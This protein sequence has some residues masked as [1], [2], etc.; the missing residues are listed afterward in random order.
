MMVVPKQ[1]QMRYEALGEL[2][3]MYKF[4]PAL[5]HLINTLTTMQLGAL[6]NEYAP[7][8]RQDEEHA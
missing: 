8:A 4:D 3:M 2:V 5:C 1:Q 7:D 6:L